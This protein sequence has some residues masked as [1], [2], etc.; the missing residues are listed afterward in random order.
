MAVTATSEANATQG[1]GPT[2]AADPVCGM[3]VDPATARNHTDHAGHRYFFCG[4]R[5][6]ERFV[7]DPGRFLAPQP[8]RDIEAG[9][10]TC[11]MHPEIVQD[12]P[13]S[14]PICGMALEPMLP[15]ADDGAD[16]ELRLM[17]RRLYVSGALAVPLLIIGMFE[18][19]FPGVVWL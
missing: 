11:P 18:I 17:T 15:T 14:C 10:Y 2:A 9:A 19:A 13:G 6:K 5:C 7:A 8:R 3:T 1:H 12:R 16:P 4:A